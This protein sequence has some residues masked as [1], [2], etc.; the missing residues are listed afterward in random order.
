MFIA[1]GVKV[2]GELLNSDIKVVELCK[3]QGSMFN[4]STSPTTGVPRSGK[5]E[6]TVFDVSEE[7]LKKI[8]ALATPN[9]VLAVAE[10]PERKL[11]IESLKDKLTLALDDI[12]DP[13][14][15]GT[16]IRVA[17]WFGIENIICSIN[18][19]DCYNPKVVQATMGSIARV[20]V[21]YGDISNIIKGVNDQAKQG[22]RI[23]GAVLDGDNIYSKKLSN[24]GIIVIGN[25]SKGISTKIASVLTDKIKI[26]ACRA[27]RP[28][29][30]HFMDSRGEPE[31]LNAAVAA[32]IICAEFRRG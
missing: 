14:N 25:E 31:S 2:V 7:E 4:G 30:A 26:P 3:V 18:T 1:E 27:G 5:E 21:F 16:I 29:T 22:F 23:F 19:V 6:I 9:E 24:K 32:A 11:D 17:D 15:M 12:Q 28:N 10:I 13:G 8:S 20:N